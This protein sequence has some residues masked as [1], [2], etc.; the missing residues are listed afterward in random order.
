[1]HAGR[2]ISRLLPSKSS[3]VFVITSPNVRRHWGQQLEA[4][5][6]KSRLNY[7]VL[8][9]NDG[10]PAKRL[11][12]VEQ[13]AEQMVSAGADRK[14]LIVA[15]GGGVVGD[16]AGFLA[17][18]FMRGIPVVQVP[19][20]VLAQADASIGG[21][22]GVNLQAGKNLIGAFHQPQ[23]VLIDS[24]VLAT[25][26]DRE[27]RAGLYESLKCGVIRDRR[28]FEF[29]AGQPEKIRERD[30]KSVERVI[31]DSVRVKAVVVSADERESGLRRILNFGHTIGHALEA[32]TGYTQLL[33]GEAIAWGMIA[34]TAIAQ[35]T[36]TCAE[37][38][39]Q[40]IRSAVMAYG[41]L[42]PVTARTEEIVARL[43]SDKKA[44][45]G[46]IHFVLP[47]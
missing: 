5:L 47:W 27:F 14:A 18:I 31:V 6:K 15:L 42:P 17:S 28:L 38:T 2:E 20:T 1:R 19:T 16:C 23:A 10:E 37:A 13:L 43:A 12:T 4:S 36:G 26:D 35:E 34:A 3:R 46:A 8:E 11:A 33:H 40:R 41:P 29:M 25:L 39:A 30:R 7:Q 45:A 44:V 9:M 21:K 24:A 22:T 32:A